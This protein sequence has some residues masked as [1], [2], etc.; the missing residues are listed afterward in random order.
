MIAGLSFHHHGLALRDDRDALVF[1]GLLGYSCG[2]KLRDPRQNVDL[3]LCTHPTMPA[4]EI[5][6]PGPGEGP[7]DA[8]VRRHAQLIYH[9]C[10][11]VDSRDA[12]L[13]QLE[14][15]GL[16][17]VEVLPPTPAVLFGGRAVSFHTVLGVGLVE[18]LDAAA[19]A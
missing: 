13:G 15:V 18:L 6:M 8:I 9:T 1:L 14:D 2:E 3:R 10:Y 7:L 19:V 11:T 17:L 5:V 4:V 12:V 16:R